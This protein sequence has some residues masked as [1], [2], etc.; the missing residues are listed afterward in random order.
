[1]GLQYK[2]FLVPELNYYF[3]FSSVARYVGI[4]EHSQKSLNDNMKFSTK[5][6]YCCAC[7]SEVVFFKWDVHEPSGCSI[8]YNSQDWK[9]PMSNHWWLDK[10]IVQYRLLFSFK[11]E[12]NFSITWMKFVG[13]ILREIRQRKTTTVWCLI[14]GIKKQNKTQ[15][16]R[17]REQMIDDC[18]GRAVGGEMGEGV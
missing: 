12:V 4:S 14:Y 6:P 3:H 15:A 16:Y 9:Q 13:I 2:S 18:P 5:L 17:C 8:I 11:K 7:S 1:M 10:V